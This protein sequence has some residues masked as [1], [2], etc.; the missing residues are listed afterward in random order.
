M[1][2]WRE[3]FPFNL[4]GDVTW[5]EVSY[6][7]S[8][9][10]RSGTIWT[11]C[12]PV[13]TEGRKLCLRAA[14]SVQEIH[15]LLPH[16]WEKKNKKKL[17]IVFSESRKKE[18]DPSGFQV[19]ALCLSTVCQPVPRIPLGILFYLEWET[20]AKS[21]VSLKFEH[22]LT[23]CSVR[24]IDFG[25]QQEEYNMKFSALSVCGAAVSDPNALANICPLF[26]FSCAM[27]CN[28]QRKQI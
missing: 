11:S 25:N 17:C 1:C 10:Y 19:A 24:V 2:R 6:L 12:S 16:C 13:L 21:A 4:L 14:F 27:Q 7:S 28:N 20:V 8:C 18:T 26:S 22:C 3:F 23:Y 5:A 9:W 15:S